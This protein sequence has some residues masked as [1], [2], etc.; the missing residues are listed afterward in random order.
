MELS[1]KSRKELT[2]VTARRYRRCGRRGKSTM[3]DEFVASTGYNRAYAG[4]LLRRY[5]AKRVT[6]AP[7]G[8]VRLVA[9]KTPRHAGGRPAV[10]D[11][12]VARAVE[13][14]WRRFGYLCG[15]RLIGLIRASL[16]FVKEERFLHIT[17]TVEQALRRIS[18]A[19]IDRMLK[20]PRAA[21]RLKGTSHTRAT[22]RVMSEIPIRTFS[23]WDGVGPGHVQLDLVGHEGG[24]SRG[25]FCCTLSVTDVCLQWTE[26]RAILNRAQRWVQAAL[27]EIRCVMPFG[28]LEL[29]P[30][31][32]SEFINGNLVRYCHD[33]GL[34][35]T[36]SRPE[37]KNDN[38]YVE[39]KNFDTVR[40]LVGYFRYESEEVVRLMNQLYIAH[41]LLLNYFIPS[42]KLM[43][44]TRTGGKVHKR[45]DPPASPAQRLLKRS[46]VPLAA[47]R[48]VARTLKQLNP[49]KLAAEVA[50]LQKQLI[51]MAQRFATAATQ[52]KDARA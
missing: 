20:K 27:D 9:T 6:S 36:R 1:M 5:R 15:K 7:Q 44:K 52:A 35:M 21:M 32:G 34:A 28:L 38:C 19:T 13:Q 48:R 25:D 11:R 3:L 24:N 18:A 22:R 8:G 2:E 10:Y 39:Q 29:H 47:R 4:L 46:D 45:Y 30:D 37:R 43:S 41:G 50:R 16:P 12:E 40:K 51:E 26:R 14:L 23:E 49:L 33:S 31:N 42:Q 17:P